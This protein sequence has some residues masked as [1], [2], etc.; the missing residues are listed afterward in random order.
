MIIMYYIYD[1]YDINYLLL[2]KKKLLNLKGHNF[3]DNFV[4]VHILYM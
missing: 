1:C 4:F 2:F 3:K